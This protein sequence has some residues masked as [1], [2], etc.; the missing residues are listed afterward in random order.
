MCKIATLAYHRHNI[1][2]RAWK[3]LFLPLVRRL[4]SRLAQAAALTAGIAA[5]YP[6]ADKVI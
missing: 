6:L 2:D 4:L 5:D 3:L 1:P